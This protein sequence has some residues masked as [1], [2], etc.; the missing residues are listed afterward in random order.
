MSNSLKMT[1]YLFKQGRSCQKFLASK[2]MTGHHAISFG[3]LGGD[4]RMGEVMWSSA[5]RKLSDGE[6]FR[7][8]MWTDGGRRVA[9]IFSILVKERIFQPIWILLSGSKPH[10]YL[11][12]FFFNTYVSFLEWKEIPRIPQGTEPYFEVEFP[13]SNET[14]THWRCDPTGVGLEVAL[15]ALL[16]LFYWQE[17][18]GNTFSLFVLFP[19]WKQTPSDLMIFLFFA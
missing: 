7:S 13:K 16:N 15:Q 2:Q 17:G 10:S 14:L 12:W 6:V 9:G 8:N 3:W 11:L 19:W 18:E 1:S 5:E 4:W